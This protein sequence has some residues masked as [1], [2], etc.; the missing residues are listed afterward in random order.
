MPLKE[1]VLVDKRKSGNL[2]RDGKYPVS[3][4]V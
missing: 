3:G 2:I 1:I 4:I